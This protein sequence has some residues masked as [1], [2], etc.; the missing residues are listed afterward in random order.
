MELSE[1]Y[2]LVRNHYLILFDQPKSK[3]SKKTRCLLLKKEIRYIS[4]FGLQLSSLQ[5][6]TINLLGVLK[7]LALFL[8]HPV[9]VFEFIM[10]TSWV[11]IRSRTTTRLPSAW[12][13]SCFT[14]HTTTSTTSGTATS[15]TPWAGRS[16]LHYQMK[17]SLL[18]NILHLLGRSRL[19]LFI[20]LY[21]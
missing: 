16:L 18:L 5:L 10:S 11:Y 17:L 3:C 14:T 21:I 13:S 8:E 19:T 7:I 20:L 4:C 1:L 15:D 12:R 2:I 6:L 9:Q